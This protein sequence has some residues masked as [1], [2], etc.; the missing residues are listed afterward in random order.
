[1]VPQ[2]TDLGSV[3]SGCKNKAVGKAG[4]CNPLKAHT[5]LLLT[6]SQRSSL[7]LSAWTLYV[8]G[9]SQRPIGWWEWFVKSS[10][11]IHFDTHWDQMH[12]VYTITLLQKLVSCLIWQNIYF[13]IAILLYAVLFIFYLPH[14]V[15]LYLFCPIIQRTY[16]FLP[17]V[18]YFSI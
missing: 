18:M 1:M 14:I 7:C 8:R 15:G 5:N 6:F 16:I 10:G 4:G 11:R 13:N 12:F 17:L 3:T 9:Q 2:W